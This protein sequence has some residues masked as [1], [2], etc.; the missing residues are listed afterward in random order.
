MAGC[1][2]GQSRAKAGFGQAGSLVLGALEHWGDC[3]P[4][5]AELVELRTPSG[6]GYRVDCWKDGLTVVVALGGGNKSSQERD[7]AKAQ[8]MVTLLKE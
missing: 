6:L 5:G 1:I 2:A 4:V 8:H 3:K 7:I